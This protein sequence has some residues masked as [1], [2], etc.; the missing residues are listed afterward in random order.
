ME[1]VI[2]PKPLALSLKK[3]IFLFIGFASLA[4]ISSYQAPLAFDLPFPGI[5]IFIICILLHCL[6][7]NF[8]TIKI[9]TVSCLLGL[10]YF[11]FFINAICLSV[12]FEIITEQLVTTFISILIFECFRNLSK[13]NAA[14]IKT[15]LLIFSFITSVQLIVGYVGDFFSDKN[16]VA[17][18]IGNSNYAATFLLLSVSF[19]LFIN[20]KWYEKL[21]ILVDVISLALTQSFGAYIAVIVVFV[22][23]LFKKLNWRLLKSWLILF[24]LIITIA[25]IF[26]YFINTSVG[27]EVYEKLSQKLTFLLM[28]DW[29]NFGSSRLELYEFSWNNIKDNFLFGTIV[30]FD[31]SLS[32]TYT[33][34]NFRTHNV[35]L[36]SLLLYGFIGTI[37]NLA[38]CV[39]LINKVLK[40]NK[41]VKIFPYIISLVAVL[42]HGMVEPNFFTMHFEP[43]VWMIIGGLMSEVEKKSKN[44]QF[45]SNVKRNNY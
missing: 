42:I 16:D 23:Y 40:R 38:I 27:S 5:L 31:S 29:K 21:I 25:V 3:N 4:I 28:G 20:T 10:R 44:I 26:Y 37:L 30:N 34:Q 24:L 12:N 14:I 6:I 13:N 2:H 36:E 18:G 22:I 7:N 15:V 39:V 33:F 43:F 9:G 11:L 35:V 41:D 32:E 8:P 1:K 19:L 45:N 17:A